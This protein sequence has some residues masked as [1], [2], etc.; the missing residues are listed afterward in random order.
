MRPWL[1][2]IR[3]VTCIS[4]GLLPARVAMRSTYMGGPYIRGWA[5]CEAVSTGLVWFL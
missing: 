1:Y 4:K 2:L 5:T 3:W